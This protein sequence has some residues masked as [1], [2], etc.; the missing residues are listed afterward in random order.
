MTVKKTWK[1][2]DVNEQ[3]AI[4]ISSAL[5]IPILLARILVN[6]GVLDL[7]Q[8]KKFLHPSFK[9]L[10]NPSLF[11]QMDEAAEHITQAILKKKIIGIFGDYDVDG[12]CSTALLQQFLTDL[13]VQVVSTLPNRMTEGYGL[14][15]Q[16]IDRLYQAGA[17][18]L[19]TVDCGILAYDQIDYANALG[20]SVIVVD[21]HTVGETL[22]NALAVINPKRSDCLSK[23]DFL[24]AAGVTFFL[25]A[26]IRRELRVNKYFANSEPNLTKLLDFVALATVCDVVPLVGDN[27]VLVRAG[28]KKIKHDPRS[29]FKALIEVSGVDN[30]KISSTNLG[31]HLGP[32]INA[33][34]RLEDASLALKLML[35]TKADEARDIA[36]NLD[37]TNLDRKSIEES[38]TLEVCELI[39]Q[40]KE[41]PQA[42]VYHNEHWHPGVVGIVASRIA[43][44]YH[45]P[46]II[47]GQNGKGSGRSIKGIDLHAMV[48]MADKSLA[49]FGGHSHAIGVSLG[50]DGVEVFRKDLL[51]VMS[52]HVSEKVFDKEILYDT[53]ILLKEVSLSLIDSLSLLEPF[54]AKNPYPIVRVNSCHIRNLRHLNG[55]HIK[56]ELESNDGYL[57][58]IGFRMS[59]TDEMANEP[60]DVLGVLEKNEWQG[61]VKPQLRLIDYRTV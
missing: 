26:A 6:R 5:N 27:R 59:M 47:I 43:E 33:A 58:F 18:V 3:A 24:C 49:G 50:S 22:P 36:Q 60:I 19:V 38:T 51:Q 53:E 4:S 14:S 7:K 32:R 46:S 23:S 34:G 48:S 2:K 31:F 12:V 35:S 8:A 16:G 40:E 1:K 39:E 41:T 25:C 11:A 9:E 30:K 55:G 20:L 45:R 57:S 44:K 21:H 28:L 10:V 13:G 56:G 15:K 37:S 52:A 61:R 54:G 29:G 42:L 17:N